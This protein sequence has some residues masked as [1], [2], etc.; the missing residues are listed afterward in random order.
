MDIGIYS[1]YRLLT[2]TFF[3][4]LVAWL[5]AV[6]GRTVELRMF[7]KGLI[8]TDEPANIKGIMSTEVRVLT[9]GCDRSVDNIND[10][11]STPV[12]AGAR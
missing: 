3:E 11:D 12:S 5:D 7:A 9:Y 1:V 4:L 2:H 8:I 10:C 6:P